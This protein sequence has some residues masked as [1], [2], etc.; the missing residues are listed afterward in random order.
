METAACGLV[1]FLISVSPFSLSVFLRTVSKHAFALFGEHLQ[2]IVFYE[3]LQPPFVS[4]LHPRISANQS[5][6][7]VLSFL[8]TNL[9]HLAIYTLLHSAHGHLWRLSLLKLHALC[10]DAPKP[11]LLSYRMD[12]LVLV[13]L[14]QKA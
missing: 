4:T 7:Q 2:A 10:K 14:Y 3:R 1:P 6:N 11:I 5:P 9:V 13:H 12:D 8:L